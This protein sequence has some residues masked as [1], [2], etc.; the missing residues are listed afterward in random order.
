MAKIDNFKDSIEEQMNY[1]QLMCKRI[2]D[3]LKAQP[4]HAFLNT[5]RI[6]VLKIFKSYISN[7]IFYWLIINPGNISQALQ[8]T[9]EVPPMLQRSGHMLSEESCVSNNEF[10]KCITL[11]NETLNYYS[12]TPS[13]STVLSCQW[14]YRDCLLWSHTKH[15]IKHA[16]K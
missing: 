8:R 4:E 3:S 15:I 16:Q 12:V 1:L 7:L 10:I 2:S 5:L 9:F 13:K 6:V 14:K 11:T